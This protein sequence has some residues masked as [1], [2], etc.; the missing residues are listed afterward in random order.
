[1]NLRE[2]ADETYT[3]LVGKA[4]YDQLAQTYGHLGETPAYLK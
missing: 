3:F 1:V 4:V 2:K